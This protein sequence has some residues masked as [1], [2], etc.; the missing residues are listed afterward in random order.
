MKHL[1]GA[2]LLLLLS[3]SA[4]LHAAEPVG[5]PAAAPAQPMP[6]YAPPPPAYYPPPAYALRP[7]QTDPAYTMLDVLLYRPLG[8][9]ATVAGLGMFVGASPFLALASIPRPH[10]AFPQAFDMLVTAPAAYTFARPLGERSLPYPH[11]Q[12]Y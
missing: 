9:A 10:D 5:R 6:Y 12:H 3:S 4:G 8:L 1:L 7:Y 2:V 11:L